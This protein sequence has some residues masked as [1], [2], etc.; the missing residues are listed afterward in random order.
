MKEGFKAEKISLQPQKK[1]RPIFGEQTSG[2]L[3]PSPQGLISS[4]IY[5]KNS[6]LIV[7]L[8]VDLGIVKPYVLWVVHQLRESLLNF[9]EM[10][11]M[12]IIL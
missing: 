3:E 5:D 7:V 6:R 8:S 11:H 4:K 10:L 12:K 9:H 2:I 1:M